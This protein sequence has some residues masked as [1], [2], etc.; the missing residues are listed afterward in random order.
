MSGESIRGGGGARAIRNGVARQAETEAV[1]RRQ[2][3]R[4]GVEL[5]RLRSKAVVV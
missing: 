1:R 4:S 5:H 2:V 3:K